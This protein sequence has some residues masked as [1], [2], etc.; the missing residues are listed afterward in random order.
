MNEK[1]LL[2]LMKGSY[3]DV[4]KSLYLILGWKCGRLLIQLECEYQMFILLNKSKAKTSVLKVLKVLGRESENQ[5]I[6]FSYFG[7][8][9]K[10]GCTLRRGSLIEKIMARF[11]LLYLDS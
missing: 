5:Q 4:T 10:V 11:S 2:G 7:W 9:R 3:S 6:D 1:A 8:K